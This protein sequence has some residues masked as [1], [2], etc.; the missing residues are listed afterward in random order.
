VRALAPDAVI[1]ATGAEPRTDGFQIASPGEPIRGVDLPHVAS[2]EDVLTGAN[3]LQGRSAL[4]VDCVGGYEAVAVA[5]HFAGQGMAVTF[6]THLDAFAPINDWRSARAL[7]R[8]DRG[9][10]TLLARHQLIEIRPGECVVRRAYAPEPKVVPAEAVVVVAPKVPRQDLAGALEGEIEQ[11][12]LVG[13][14]RSPRDM[15][16]AIA[17]GHRAARAIV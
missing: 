3:H 8:L 4:V 17:E 15:Q 5:E 9:D 1:L 7:E 13:D 2:S 14:A 10:F 12:T 16:F 11:L 6:V